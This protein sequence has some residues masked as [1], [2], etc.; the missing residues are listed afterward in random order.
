MYVLNIEYRDGSNDISD[1]ENLA[2]VKDYM[3]NLVWEAKGAM[4]TDTEIYLYKEVNFTYTPPVSSL[5]V[6]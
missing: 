6:D 1:H 2:S 3:D 4:P 5:V